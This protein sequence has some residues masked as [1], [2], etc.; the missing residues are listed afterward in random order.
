MHF[1]PKALRLFN[2]DS[3]SVYIYPDISSL[4]NNL[5]HTFA[6]FTTLTNINNSA[7]DET[8][9]Y[10]V[11]GTI[12]ET[13]SNITRFFNAFRT[14]ALDF[15]KD[16]NNLTVLSYH[17]AN[18]LRIPN[19]VDGSGQLK[20]TANQSTQNRRPVG[21]V[22]AKL[23][24]NIQYNITGIDK[25]NAETFLFTFYVR[26]KNEEIDV[27]NDR[28]NNAPNFISFS[29]PSNWV[30]DGNKRTFLKCISSQKQSKSHSPSK[31]HQM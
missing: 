5:E 30:S 15:I 8:F 31:R 25:P 29:S 18:G 24:A 12:T 1:T 16:P 22:F 21:I 11:L 7:Y 6:W 23:Q 20:P 17:R 14:F 9:K 13:S 2:Q 10:L 26:V 4:T 19:A 3:K 27:S 28:G